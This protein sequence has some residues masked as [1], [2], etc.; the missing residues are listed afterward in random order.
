M[1]T[2]I[3]PIALLALLA[4]PALPA[5]A[6][7][8]SGTR[9]GTGHT[10]YVNGTPYLLDLVTRA[11]CDWQS[12]D[13]ILERQPYLE[14]ALKEISKL[15]WYFAMDLRDELNSLDFCF[16]GPLYRVDPALDRNSPIQGPSERLRQ[17]GL[18]IGKT[19]YIDQELYENKDS[20]NQ[21]MS[22]IHEVTHSYLSMGLSDRGLKHRS[23][24]R[25]LDQVASG[26]ETTI[27]KL[28]LS[29]RQNGVDFPLTVTKLNP[30]RAQVEFIKMDLSA[31][32]EILLRAS[33]PLELVRLSD[34]QIN[35]L[36]RWDQSRLQLQG[37]AQLLLRTIL[38]EA[39]LRA[40]R[41]QM[42]VLLA[43]N[44]GATNPIR[45]ALNLFNQLSQG[46]RSAVLD[47]QD[48]SAYA[49]SAVESISQASV[50]SG[51]RV[52]I[53]SVE[54]QHLLGLAS[55]V[56]V[57]R[58]LLSLGFSF[59]LSESLDWLPQLLVILQESGDL[60]DFSAR[61]QLKAVLALSTQKQSVNTMER[62]SSTQK[63]VSIERLELLSENLKRQL[64]A[65]LAEMTTEVQL[66]EILKQL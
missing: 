20:R 64:V 48:F 1:K 4:M 34:A 52:A 58:P 41:A 13:E 46:A 25:I 50:K 33:Q 36:S 16:T 3:K 65:R 56:S 37:G 42:E 10:T 63:S 6:V 22:I 51:D 55:G 43:K 47:H 2:I 44:Y 49:V 54:L 7:E 26:K 29:F 14:K 59:A 21:A 38:A 8:G 5:L 24:V 45:V 11:V 60:A 39:M 61:T 15:D 32:A 30:V 35:L 62:L 18:R 23:L 12:A 57:E 40:D 28:H 19:V 9:G 31:Q 27:S 17:M 53:A 66:T